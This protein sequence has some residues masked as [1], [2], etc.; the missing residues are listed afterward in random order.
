MR[1]TP[2]FYDFLC[3]LRNFIVYVVYLGMRC[4]LM[5]SAHYLSFLEACNLKLFSLLAIR[6]TRGK[7]SGRKLSVLSENILYSPLFHSPPSIQ[8]GVCLSTVRTPHSDYLRIPFVH[9][10]PPN[11][12][13]CFSGVSL[14]TTK[15]KLAPK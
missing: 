13:Q 3:L 9:P 12:Q 5:C 2:T 11:E 15:Q 1:H 4:P 8:F 10:P 7:A 14:I 6:W